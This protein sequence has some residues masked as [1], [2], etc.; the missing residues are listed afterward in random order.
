QL[1]QKQELGGTSTATRARTQTASSWATSEETLSIANTP[2]LARQDVLR[3]ETDEAEDLDER[4]DPRAPQRER[5]K[6]LPEWKVSRW[7]IRSCA[8]EATNKHAES[9]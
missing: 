3:R 9:N 6:D 8:P 1:L 5:T 4:L 7:W 2:T